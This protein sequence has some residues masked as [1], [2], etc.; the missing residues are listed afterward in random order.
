MRL[1]WAVKIQLQTLWFPLQWMFK[2][3]KAEMK[4][5]LQDC[6]DDV[7]RYHEGVQ[8]LEREMRTTKLV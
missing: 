5:R 4:E 6:E 8:E 1:A 3:T 7:L 2:R